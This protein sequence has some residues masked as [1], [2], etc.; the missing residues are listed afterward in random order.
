MISLEAVGRVIGSPFS[1]QSAAFFGMCGGKGILQASLA[2]VSAVTFGGMPACDFTQQILV[3]TSLGLLD[4]RCTTL[5][6]MSLCL[7]DE[8]ALWLLQ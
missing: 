5:A 2:K 1:D 3:H 4:I 6:I 7:Q 8:R